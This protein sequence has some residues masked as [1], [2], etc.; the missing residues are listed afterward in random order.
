MSKSAGPSSP[1]VF[2]VIEVLGCVRLLQGNR[3]AGW[4]L[5][6]GVLRVIASG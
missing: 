2:I 6:E 4:G 3:G 1:Q 5:S